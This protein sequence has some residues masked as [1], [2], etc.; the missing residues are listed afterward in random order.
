MMT[1]TASLLLCLRGVDS[2]TPLT[3][4]VKAAKIHEMLT[5]GACATPGDAAQA[6]VES[7]KK[8]NHCQAS[9]QFEKPSQS[10]SVSKH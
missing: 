8:K 6:P 1:F 5:L 3:V 10:I 4:C 2:L 9:S 7:K